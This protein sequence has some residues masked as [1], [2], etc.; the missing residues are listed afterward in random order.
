MWFLR[1]LQFSLSCRMLVFIY[2]DLDLSAFLPSATSRSIGAW[3]EIA[4]AP[5]LQAPVLV[6]KE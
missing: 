4:I 6:I 1:L 5:M 3:S 2:H